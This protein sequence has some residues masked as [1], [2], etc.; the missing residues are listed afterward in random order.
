[1]IAENPVSLLKPPDVPSA[2]KS[3]YTASQLTDLLWHADFSHPDMLPFIALS[4]F[5]FLRTAKL[6]RLYSDEDVLRWEDIGHD[7]IH[8]R[9]T[10]GKAT[11]AAPQVTNDSC[12]YPYRSGIGST[13]YEKRTVLLFLGCIPNFRNAGESSVRT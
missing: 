3:V 9:E 7:R 1:M 8:V 6:I 4:A 2:K 11:R 12:R 13:R 5:A 10:V